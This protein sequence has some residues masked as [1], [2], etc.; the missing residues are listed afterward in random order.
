MSQRNKFTSLPF[1][2][3]ANSVLAK[4]KFSKLEEPIHSFTESIS[5]HGNAL[6]YFDCTEPQNVKATDSDQLLQ[7][8]VGNA[9]VIFVVTFSVSFQV[10]VVPSQASIFSQTK[11]PTVVS[12]FT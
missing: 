9:N 7:L 5:I 6:S 1:N 2:C 10:W 12:H 4:T 3:I 11:R 8:F